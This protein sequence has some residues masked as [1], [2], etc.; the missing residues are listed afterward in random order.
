MFYNRFK[1]VQKVAKWKAS[2]IKSYIWIVMTLTWLPAFTIVPY[3]YDT[4][5]DFFTRLNEIFL[6]IQGYGGLIYNVYFTYEFAKF[7]KHASAR[8][9]ATALRNKKIAIK[10]I[11]HCFSSSIGTVLAG[12]YVIEGA[13][14]YIIVIPIGLHFLFNFRLERLLVPQNS[15]I[16]QNLLYVKKS[17]HDANWDGQEDFVE[18]SAKIAA[19]KAAAEWHPAIFFRKIVRSTRKPATIFCAPIHGQ[20]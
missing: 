10:S 15:C 1:A 14:L 12:Y 7:L 9:S 20:V 17:R 16:V 3:F 18:S 8:H 13:L 5:S 19:T 4:N 11:I 2:A 6:F